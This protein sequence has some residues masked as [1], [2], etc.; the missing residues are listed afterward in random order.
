VGQKVRG[1]NKSFYTTGDFKDVQLFGQHLF[2]TGGKRVLVVEGEIDALSGGQML[3]TWPV[4]SLPSGAAG[5]VKAVND[6]IEWLESYERVVFGFDMDEPGREAASACAALLSPGKAAIMELPRK[7]ANEMLVDGMVKEFVTAFWEAREYRPD[8]IVRLADIRERILTPPEMG[9]PWWLESLSKVTYGRRLGETYAFGAGTGIGK[10]DFL[11]QQI[12]YDV[13]V[14]GEKV[15][16]FFL[17]QSPSE[18]AKR[19][20]NKFAGKR[21]HVPDGSWTQDELVAVID[22]LQADDRLFFYDNFGALEWVIVKGVIK[23]LAQAHGVRLFYLDHL[24]ALAAAEEDERKALERIMA[25]MAQLAKAL[26]VIIH[27]VSHLATPDGKPHEEGGRVMI[28]H[29]K[30]S[31]A[32]GFWSHFMFGLERDTQAEDDAVKTITTF[33]VLKDRN[34]GD[35]NGWTTFLGYDKENGR[36]FETSSP[37]A[38]SLLGEDGS[39]DY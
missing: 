39:E 38:T 13:D 11:T 2:K 17:E 19:V 15:G 1:P 6:N 29:F 36:L 28:R 30:G 31:R 14:L 4:V 9:L 21:F 10:T 35:S 23:Y 25:D 20:A 7:D 8:G 16:L 18:T 26:N 32:I 33:R 12:Q 24:T 27:F 34:T 5:A 3:S 37:D 22:R